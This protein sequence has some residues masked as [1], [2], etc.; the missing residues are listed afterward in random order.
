LPL[1]TL[2]RFERWS[3]VL[4]EP[5]SADTGFIAR[6]LNGHARALALM[7]TGQAA[8]ARALQAELAQLSPPQGK[9]DGS[10]LLRSMH[11]IVLSRLT[12]DL[13]QFDGR[14]DAALAAAQAAVAAEDALEAREP[15]LLAV[16][17]RQAQGQM[18]LRAGRAAEAEAAFRADLADQP[19]SGWA[20]R[21]LHAA[22]QRQGKS[23]EAAQ[24]WQ[25]LQRAWSAADPALHKPSA[26]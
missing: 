13:A 4:A 19:G 6:T 8:A 26:G 25:Q 22:L 16:M 21:G 18:L 7:H 10:E 3:E 2:A 5:P 24:V 14:S 17:A 9:N 1:H 12:A 11:S 15:P 23:A 20:L